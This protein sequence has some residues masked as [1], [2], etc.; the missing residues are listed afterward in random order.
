MPKSMYYLNINFPYAKQIDLKQLEQ[1][2]KKRK[3]K[4]TFKALS[5]KAFHPII[6]LTKLNF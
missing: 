1:K 5:D 4:K 2:E 6:H 3:E